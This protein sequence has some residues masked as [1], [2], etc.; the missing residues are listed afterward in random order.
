MNN[1][2]PDPIDTD[3]DKYKVIL[4]NDRVRVLE[5]HDTPGAKT[6][7]HYHRA[8]VLYAMSNF[9]RKLTYEDGRMT[10]RDFKPG[11]VIWMEAQSHIG[12]NVGKT[13]TEVVIVEIKQL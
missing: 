11:D 6:T 4:E 5:Y 8:F 3:P 10:T 2:K 9:T 12:E 13:N 7:M 1:I